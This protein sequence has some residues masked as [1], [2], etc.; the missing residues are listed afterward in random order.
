MGAPR[1]VAVLDADVLVPAGLRDVLLSLAAEGLYRPVWQEQILDEMARNATRLRIES[2]VDQQTAL[3]G[4]AHLLEQMA[5]AFPDGALGR[6]EWEAL[7]DDLTNDPKDRHVLAAAVAADVSHL[8]TSN[9]KD[10]PKNS[11]PVGIAVMKPNTFACQLLDDDPEGVLAAIESISA[12]L[13]SPHLTVVEL[14]KSMAGGQNLPLFG[15][16]LLLL[17]AE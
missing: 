12:R 9:T 17:L 3:L 8:V 14:A 1:P 16:R 2:G 13:N 15:E 4:A 10:F 6:A 11:V 7:T 5:R